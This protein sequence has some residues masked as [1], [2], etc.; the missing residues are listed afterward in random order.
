MSTD[1]SSTRFCGRVPIPGSAPVHRTTCD[2][3]SCPSIFPWLRVPDAPGRRFPDRRKHWIGQGRANF[4][5]ETQVT[6]TRAAGGTA[7]I[8]GFDSSAVTCVENAG[9][10]WRKSRS[11]VRKT[12]SPE[13]GSRNAW[14]PGGRTHPTAEFPQNGELF[15]D[16]S[17][18]RLAVLLI[19]HR[20]KVH[21]RDP[22]VAGNWPSA[23][24][25]AV[26]AS[27]TTSLRTVPPCHSTET[28]DWSTPERWRL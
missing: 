11:R 7:Q 23:T 5:Q 27:A 3:D 9:T 19:V 21:R 12:V 4:S 6:T 1:E 17:G 13:N 15:V 26:A 10:I 24:T 20:S 25:A 8:S 28:P 22:S 14:H 18:N 16:R 2:G